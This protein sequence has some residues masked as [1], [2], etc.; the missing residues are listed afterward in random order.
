MPPETAMVYRWCINWHHAAEKS[1]EELEIALEVAR[2][3]SE[4]LRKSMEGTTGAYDERE[5]IDR[6]LR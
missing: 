6:L 2:K 5:T 1:D 4:N 3:D